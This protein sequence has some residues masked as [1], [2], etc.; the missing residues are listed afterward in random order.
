LRSN[1]RFHNGRDVA[2]GTRVFDGRAAKFHDRWIHNHVW[3]AATWRRFRQRRLDA[4]FFEKRLNPKDSRDKSRP[5]KALTSQRTPQ[6]KR[7]NRKAYDWPLIPRNFSR[8]KHRRV[9]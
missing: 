3:S 5:T 7:A 2:K 1:G 4:A 6:K 9:S 8:Q